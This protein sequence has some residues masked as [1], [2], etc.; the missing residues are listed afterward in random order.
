MGT[1]EPH[2]PFDLGSLTD[3][4]AEDPADGRHRMIG[5][6]AAVAIHVAVLSLN[7]PIS[8]DPLPEPER[9]PEHRRVI[10]YNP[11]PRPTPVLDQQRPE[12][13]RDARPIP[14]PENLEPEIVERILEPLDPPEFDPN[15]QPVIEFHVP[16]PAPAPTPPA[17]IR[18]FSP[19][20]ILTRVEPVYPPGA[21]RA[22]IEGTVILEMTIDE[23]GR[24]IDIQV[25]RP[26]PFGLTQAAVDA[27]RQWRFEPCTSDGRPV[28]VQF[29]L[30]VR[31]NRM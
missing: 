17:T 4:V 2:Q 21:L 20:E 16:A 26:Q 14:V 3:V 24:P 18:V 10:L 12:F 7:I 25:L 31:F 11:P 29:T 8:A 28:R 6:V 22:G 1:K 9:L 19:P 23:R 30:T 15:A 27:A 13:R 5:V